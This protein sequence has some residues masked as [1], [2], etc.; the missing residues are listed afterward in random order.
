[1]VRPIE[2]AGAAVHP[3][4]ARPDIPFLPHPLLLIL[5]TPTGISRKRPL[6]RCETQGDARAAFPCDQRFRK[7]FPPP[8]SSLL[9]LTRP[10]ENQESG[11]KRTLAGIGLSGL[12]C[13]MG[14]STK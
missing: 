12:E 10:N 3:H 13:E 1:M 6:H 7:P 11:E 8:C 14:L 9:R 4:A 5:T 2:D